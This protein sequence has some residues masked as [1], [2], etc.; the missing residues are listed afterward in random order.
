[1]ERKRRLGR[2]KSPTIAKLEKEVDKLK[3]QLTGE[4]PVDPGPEDT[5]TEEAY[6]FSYDEKSKTYKLHIFAYDPK[7]GKSSLIE[8]S[9]LATSQHRAV[10]E[11][12]K[13][14]VNAIHDLK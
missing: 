5:M 12:K 6:G 4:V 2:K 10:F 8:A 13:L 3:K 9:D 7:S 11:A 1:M 14:I